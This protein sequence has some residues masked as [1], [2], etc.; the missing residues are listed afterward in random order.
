MANSRLSFYFSFI[1]IFIQLSQKAMGRYTSSRR[2]CRPSVSNVRTLSQWYIGDIE[3]E[4]EQPWTNLNG[5]LEKTLLYPVLSNISDIL[6]GLGFSRNNPMWLRPRKVRATQFEQC[7]RKAWTRFCTADLM[8][9]W[10]LAVSFWFVFRKL[11]GK[12]NLTCSS[13]LFFF[14][15]LIKTLNSPHVLYVL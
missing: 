9:L 4:F 15:R 7:C 12:I 10:S 1:G 6:R 2:S 13:Q 11:S 14:Y 5:Y 3:P 8:T